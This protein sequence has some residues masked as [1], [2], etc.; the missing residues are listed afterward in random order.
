MQQ[1]PIQFSRRRVLSLAFKSIAAA[2]A[3]AC[4]PMTTSAD[5]VPPSQRTQ[6]PAAPVPSTAA[7]V[8]PSVSTTLTGP[9][10]P[11]SVTTDRGDAIILD[12]VCPADWGASPPQT[13]FEEHVIDRITIHHTA[14]ALY[15]ESLAMER[16]RQHQTYHQSLGWPD[17]AYHFLIGPD[18]TVLAGRPLKYRG[19][20]ATDYDPARHLLICLEGNF[21]EQEVSDAQWMSL[22][23]MTAWGMETFEVDASRVKGHRD[24]ASTSCPGDFVARMMEDGLLARSVD[25]VDGVS[26]SDSCEGP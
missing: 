2:A 23:R 17:L 8:T 25:A 22:S 19:D 4:A 26:T 5:P 1:E 6:I 9:S 13:G 15:D 10:V 7:R 16:A 18:G 12:I 21:D 11:Q 20:T 3:G 14:V 24:V